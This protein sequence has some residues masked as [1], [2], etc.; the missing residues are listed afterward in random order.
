VK[1]LDRSLK[2]TVPAIP[3]TAR[4]LHEPPCRKTTSVSVLLMHPAAL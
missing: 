4:K 2:F 3:G 1:E